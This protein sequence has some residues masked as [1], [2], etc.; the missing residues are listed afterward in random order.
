M[1]QKRQNKP[2]QQQK[3][4]QQQQPQKV[5]RIEDYMTALDG[6]EVEVHVLYGNTILKLQGTLHSQAKFNIILD[7]VDEK[8]KPQK[9]FINKAF[10]VF[11]KPL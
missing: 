1:Q 11:I 7:F 6:Y 8:G 2:A 9:L 5:Q 3:P 4:Q 10:V